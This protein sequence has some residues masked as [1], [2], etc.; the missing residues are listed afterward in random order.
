MAIIDLINGNFAGQF[1]VPVDNRSLTLCAL[2]SFLCFSS[3]SL[4]GFFNSLSFSFTLFLLPIVFLLSFSWRASVLVNACRFPVVT[5]FF[6][7]FATGILSSSDRGDHCA[8]TELH[9]IP[10][11]LEECFLIVILNYLL[12]HADDEILQNSEGTC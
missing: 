4:I 11:M 6:G 10:Q 12:N 7:L 5:F 1:Q 8:T 9:L 3:S 2:S